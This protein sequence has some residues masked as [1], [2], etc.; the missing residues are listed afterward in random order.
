MA[1]YRNQNSWR[2]QTRKIQQRQWKIR[3]WWYSSKKDGLHWPFLTL[4]TTA[5]DIYCHIADF[6]LVTAAHSTKHF[7]LVVSKVWSRYKKVYFHQSTLKTRG[8]DSSVGIATGYWLDG[9]GIESRW[10]ARFSAPVQT[11]PGAHPTSCT[12]GNESFSGV[13]RGPGCDADPSSP[14]IAV[15]MKE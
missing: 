11:G 14:S 10:G 4:T 15:V 12:I 6:Q 5:V 3:Q 1:E 2:N 8:R 13:K 7:C 9:P